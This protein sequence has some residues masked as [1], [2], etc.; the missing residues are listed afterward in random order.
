MGAPCTKDTKTWGSRSRDISSRNERAT[1]RSQVVDI[2]EKTFKRD[3][4]IFSF[5]N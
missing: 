1:G 4:V 3:I 5:E 2:L